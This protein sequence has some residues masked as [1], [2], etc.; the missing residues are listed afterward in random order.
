MD[1]TASK[2]KKFFAKKKT[3][4]KFKLA[5]PGRKLN[6]EPPA[7]STSQKPSKDAYVPIKRDELSAEAK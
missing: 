5:G 3:E 4:A 1:A 7:P 6:A 2:I